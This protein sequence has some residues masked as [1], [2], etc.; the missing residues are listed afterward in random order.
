MAFIEPVTLKGAHTTLEPLAPEHEGAL[1][2]AAAD[3]ELWRLWY[4][5]VGQSRQGWARTSRP[6]SRHAR[7][8]RPMPFVVRDNSGEIVGCT[9]YFNVDVANRRL[10][11]GHTWYS[12]RAARCLTTECKLLPLSTHA[13]EKAP[14]HRGRIPYTGSTMHRAPRSR[15][16]ARSRMRFAQTRSPD[17]A[18]TAI[19]SCSASSERV[20]G[21]QAA[22]TVSARAAPVGVA[23]GSRHARRFFLHLR[24]RS[25]RFIDARIPDAARRSQAR[26][27]QQRHRRFY[28]LART[29]MVK[30]E[31]AV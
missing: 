25:C 14:V 8:P 4:A 3:G 2:L 24:Q 9:R 16:S 21:R 31:G 22:S 5:W 11:I 13:F 1:K 19:R 7:A 28:V 12:K 27:R 20:A 26:R 15:D 29:C 30:D 10:E 18:A 23:S 6:R 17:G